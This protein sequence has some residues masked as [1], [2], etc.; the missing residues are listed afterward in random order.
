MLFINKGHIIRTDTA[1]ILSQQS[2]EKQNFRGNWV[3][4]RNELSLHEQNLVGHICRHLTLGC[5]SGAL[6]K[7]K[8]NLQYIG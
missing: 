2:I 3:F 6:S 8:C 5:L 7:Y 1:V 4:K